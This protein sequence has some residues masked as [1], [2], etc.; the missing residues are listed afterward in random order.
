MQKLVDGVMHFQSQVFAPQRELFE[1]LARGQAPHTLFVACSDSRIDPNL[2]TNS[3]PGEL[4]VVRNP[5]NLVAP[6]GM[7]NDAGAAV[8]FALVNFSLQD[9]VVCGHTGC[10][11]M[12]GLFEPN[13]VAGLPT[14]A[15]WLAHAEHVRGRLDQQPGH[16]D[17]NARLNAAVEE[18]VLLQLDHL[19]TYPLVA[20]RIARGR[21]RLHAWVYRLD[22][23]GV[24]VHDPRRG[25]YVSLTGSDVAHPLAW[26]GHE[27]GS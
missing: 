20:E 12:Q 11:A 25:M 2:I 3:K 19:R 22:T 26:S 17:A 8:E 9:I 6:Y 13:Q 4:F 18:N 24:R 16:A 1:G 15:R 10:G 27:Y 23:G 7:P 5:G 21:L 14:L